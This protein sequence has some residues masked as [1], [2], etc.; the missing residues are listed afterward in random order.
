MLRKLQERHDLVKSLHPLAW[1][2]PK[3][4]LRRQTSQ[5]SET[6]VFRPLEASS[7]GTRYFESQSKGF[8]GRHALNNLLGMPQF[9][10][11]DFGTACEM[12]MAI[13]DDQRDQH[14]SDDGW[15]SHS[16]LGKVFD[17]IDPPIWRMLSSPQELCSYDALVS[18][19]DVIGSVV[20]QNGRHWT[21]VVKHE[22][23]V[24]HVDSM[25]APAKLSQ[26]EHANLMKQYPMTFAVVLH[27]K[28]M[29]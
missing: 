4:R 9:S 25:S 28:G 3:S 26:V 10:D 11:F 20:N 6:E 14:V 1:S 8:C 15:Y 5:P 17:T 19:S 13:T 29:Y 24:W 2:Q 21:C 23:A 22:S 12:V 16:V 18:N 7:W 27:G